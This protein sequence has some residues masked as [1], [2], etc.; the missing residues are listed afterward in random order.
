MSSERFFKLCSRAP[1]IPMASPFNPRD[2]DAWFTA[3]TLNR[4]SADE[5]AAGP[6]EE[7]EGG[8]GRGLFGKKPLRNART[9]G[10]LQSRRRALARIESKL[11]I[12]AWKPFLKSARLPFS[13]T[14]CRARQPCG[15]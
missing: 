4:K 2:V 7:T 12:I 9:Q 1:T 8:A 6:V 11:G 15:F 3:S 14:T 13:A 10:I 5:Q